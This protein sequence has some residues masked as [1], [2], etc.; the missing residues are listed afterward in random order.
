MQAISQ[1]E[2]NLLG[3]LFEGLSAIKGLSILGPDLSDTRR[4][5]TIALRMNSHSPQ[6][7]AEHLAAHNICA[8]NGH[9]YAL[10][11]SEV[12]GWNATGGVVRLGLS[13]YSSVEDVER[14]I[15]AF[16]EL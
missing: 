16:G 6:Q 11:A 13:A 15:E 2:K 5:P 8:W 1:H 7:I 12:M 10:R 3:Q 14:V 4:S 9:F